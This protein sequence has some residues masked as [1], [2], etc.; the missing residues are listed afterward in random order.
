M[1]L[2][3]TDVSQRRHLRNEV[4]ETW[5]DF[6][7]FVEKLL[8]MNLLAALTWLK[9]QRRFDPGSIDLWASPALL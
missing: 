6:F 4:S 7:D 3:S 1:K 8:S 2:F 5:L 9:R